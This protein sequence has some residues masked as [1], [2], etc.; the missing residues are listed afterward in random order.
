MYYCNIYERQ[1]NFE[2]SASITYSEDK[3]SITSVDCKNISPNITILDTIN[4]IGENLF[5]NC[6]NIIE[7]NFNKIF[8]T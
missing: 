6:V 1:E 5:R 2:N 7:T 4:S 3:K 8:I